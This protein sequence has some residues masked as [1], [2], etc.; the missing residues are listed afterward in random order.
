MYPF[1][2]RIASLLNS[3]SIRFFFR[4]RS[5]CYAIYMCIQS[6]E[7][8]NI[9]FLGVNQ[10]RIFTI[11]FVFF[12]VLLL[13]LFVFIYMKRCHDM[14]GNI[15]PDDENDDDDDNYKEEDI[16]MLYINI[17]T[18]IRL[19]VWWK[20]TYSHDDMN[21]I[22]ASKST[23]TLRRREVWKWK[24]FAKKKIIETG[25]NLHNSIAN[26]FSLLYML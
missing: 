8:E 4:D 10:C 1:L 7:N 2:Y 5:L 3:L 16:C 19:Y 21:I 20:M 17:Y 14:D 6:D 26:R 25:I 13:F 23:H 11:M 15:L 12:F 22:I 18:N 9:F 24:S